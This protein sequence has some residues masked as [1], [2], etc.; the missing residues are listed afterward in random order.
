MKCN[1][2]EQVNLLLEHID[3]ADAVC[4]G[5]A[6]GMSV[7]AGYDCAYHNDKYFEKYLGEFGRKYGFEGSFNG[8][9]YRY[10]TSEE[11]WAREKSIFPCPPFLFQNIGGERICPE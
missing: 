1:F 3:K 7:A 4:V 9:Y 2:N 5:A 11:R 10:Q 6:A 8:Y